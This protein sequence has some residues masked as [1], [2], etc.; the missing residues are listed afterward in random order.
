MSAG[1]SSEFFKD[2]AGGGPPP[3]ALLGARVHSRTL[4]H[5]LQQELHL[6]GQDLAVTQDERF[7]PVRHVRHVVQSHPS[8]F[9]RAISLA[10]VA[11]LARG[12][13][14]GPGVGATFRARH[15]VLHVE[16]VVAE[17]L[18]AVRADVAVAGQQHVL[19]ERRDMIEA[20]DHEVP[21]LDRDDRAGADRRLLTG[22]TLRAASKHE[23]VR[24]NGPRDQVGRVV[25]R[26][27]AHVDPPVRSASDV[28]RENV[29]THSA[30]PLVVGNDGADEGI[31]TSGLDAGDV[32]FCLT[33]D[34][35]EFNYDV[36][37]LNSSIWTPALAILGCM[38]RDLQFSRQLMHPQKFQSE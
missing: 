38:T 2:A 25:M 15:D 31:R 21:A 30:P 33:D 23:L 3:P 34:I 17:T 1:R 20:A 6:V 12:H 9:R 22:R 16:L 4:R 24:T 18:R 29:R 19:R 5:T 28:E 32:A 7:I 37:W 14:V 10:V 36:R 26:S 27:V 8:G 13:E 35:R 11:R